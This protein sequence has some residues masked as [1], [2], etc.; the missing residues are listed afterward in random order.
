VSA[1]IPV[2]PAV[3]FGLNYANRNWTSVPTSTAPSS[4]AKPDGNSSGYGLVLGYAMS[5]KT[6]LT[7]QYAQYNTKVTDVMKSNTFNV[8][9]ATAF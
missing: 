1:S 9:L 7:A 8:A 4:T 2:T 6:S 3:T 5:K